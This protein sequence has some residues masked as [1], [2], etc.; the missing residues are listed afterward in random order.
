MGT[1]AANDLHLTS[2]S[3]AKVERGWMA[4]GKN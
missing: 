4:E 2:L 3:L 1:G